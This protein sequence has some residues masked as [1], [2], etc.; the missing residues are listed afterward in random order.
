MDKYVFELNREGV[1]E[2]MRSPAMQQ[3]LDQIASQVS[4]R[5]GEGYEVINRVGKTRASATVE[6]MTTEAYYDNLENNTIL[7]ALQG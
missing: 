3:G 2:L 1:A 5:C 7:R 6:A 4:S